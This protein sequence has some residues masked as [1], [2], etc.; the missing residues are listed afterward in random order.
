MN[1]VI[2]KLDAILEFLVKLNCPL[3]NLLQPPLE[4]DEFEKL[5]AGMPI[6]LPDEVVSL[7]K[8]RNGVDSK[9]DNFL[10]GTWLFPRAVFYEFSHTVSRYKEGAGR[11]KFWNPTKFMLFETGGGEL[12]LIECNPDSSNFGT[13]YKYDL[14]AIEFDTLIPIYDSIESLLDTVLECYS[15]GIYTCH[16]LTGVI[17]E[18]DEIYLREYEISKKTIPDLPI[19]L[20][21]VR[22]K[23]N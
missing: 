19:G 16:S 1:T 4:E 9:S 12:Y 7:F 11:D 17:T 15:N 8:W 22:M 14:C 18:N 13:I 5:M 10:G 6:T 20:F 2:E 21:L 23:C 3:V